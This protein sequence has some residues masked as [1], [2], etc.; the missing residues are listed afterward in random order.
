MRLI[1]DSDDWP[2]DFGSNLSSPEEIRHW[3]GHLAPL[4]VK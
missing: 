1:K 3:H 2:W 4:L